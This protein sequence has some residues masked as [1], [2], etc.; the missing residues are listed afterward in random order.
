MGLKHSFLAR[1]DQLNAA[2]VVGIQATP[3]DP[4]HSISCPQ[5]CP[6]IASGLRG[7]Q[8][9]TWGVADGFLQV[10]DVEIL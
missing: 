8:V 7:P 9:G 1:N 5:T 2:L 3:P 4:P 6:R 10:A